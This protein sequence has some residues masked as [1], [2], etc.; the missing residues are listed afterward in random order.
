MTYISKIYQG[1][2]A[3][4]VEWL[5]N[6][7]IDLGIMSKVDAEGFDYEVIYKD[8]LLCVVPK[9]F[10]KSTCFLLAGLT[11]EVLV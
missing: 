8:R 2:Y 11:K 9:D 10:E 3:D 6:G 1:T 4:L 7:T 5:R